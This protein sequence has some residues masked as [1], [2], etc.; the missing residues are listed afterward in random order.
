MQS[1]GKHD[2]VIMLISDSYL[3]SSNCMYEVMEVMRDR[4]YKDRILFILLRD[5]DKKYYMLQVFHKI[6]KDKV[7]L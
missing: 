5:E 4:Q 7:L 2:Y 3:K 6:M 1:I